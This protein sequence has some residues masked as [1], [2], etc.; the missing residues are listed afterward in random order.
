MPVVSWPWL[1][2]D[3]LLEQRPAEPLGGAAVHLAL[4]QRRVQR[5]ADVLGDD[6]AEHG[7]RARV[8][9]DA[10]VGEVGGG[11]RGLR[12]GDASV[13]LD[14][15]VRAAE[16][17]GSS[18]RARS[19]GIALAGTPTRLH[20]AVDDLEVLGGD[21]ELLGGDRRAAARAPRSRRCSTARPTV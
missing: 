3:Q 15:R 4:D 9:I 21:L 14:R 20:R 5:A 2:V 17:A 7:D 11:L 8:G 18:R 13:A 19:I 1:V 10:D 6:V 12:L 16:A